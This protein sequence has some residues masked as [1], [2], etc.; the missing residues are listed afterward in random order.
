MQPRVY[1]RD[2]KYRDLDISCLKH[3]KKEFYNFDNDVADSILIGLEDCVDPSLHPM[4]RPQ[5][6]RIGKKS[7]WIDSLYGGD[8]RKLMG[9]HFI[10][11][12][13]MAKLREELHQLKKEGPHVVKHWEG[14]PFP[15]HERLIARATDHKTSDTPRRALFEWLETQHRWEIDWTDVELHFDTDFDQ[16]Y[17]GN[18]RE[19]P[20]IGE[21]D[22]D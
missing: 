15:R 3:N 6:K 21:H 8:K 16:W 2:Q 18:Y 11:D 19:S 5:Y 9:I 17:Y 20:N 12:Y 7:S 4:L 14:I 1:P 13:H 10:W 22:K